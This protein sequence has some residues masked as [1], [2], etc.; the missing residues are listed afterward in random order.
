MSFQKAADLLR[1]AEMATAEEAK[2]YG[3]VDKVIERFGGRPY[4]DL[5]V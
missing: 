1:L 5:V 4:W 3:L 2:A